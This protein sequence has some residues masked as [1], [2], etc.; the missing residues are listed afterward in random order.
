MNYLLLNAPRKY[1]SGYTWCPLEPR[2]KKDMLSIREKLFSLIAELEL[3]GWRSRDIFW[4]GHSQGCLVACDLVLNHP[5]P[6]GGLIGVSGYV[7]FFRGWK[8]RARSSGAKETPW[9][10]TH[11]TRDRVILPEEIREDV[12][13]LTGEVPVL[14]R[15]FMKGHDFD[16]AKEVPF[17][18]SWIAKPWRERQALATHNY[19]F[20]FNEGPWM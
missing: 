9:L 14:Y 2:R 20:Q 4:L 16:Y 1:L 3:A 13:L 8:H 5:K 6:F 7:W 19:D 15:E 11:G 12:A 18:R 10:L 17:I